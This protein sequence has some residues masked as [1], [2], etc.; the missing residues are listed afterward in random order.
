LFIAGAIFVLSGFGYKLFGVPNLNQY[1][2]SDS[3]QIS[4]I[5]DRFS[6]IN[7]IEDI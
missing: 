2:N 3:T 7:E 1:F 6:A 5:N 4:I